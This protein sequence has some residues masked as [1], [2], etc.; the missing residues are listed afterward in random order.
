MAAAAAQDLPSGLPALSFYADRARATA[1]GR[2]VPVV[3]GWPAYPGMV[4]AI[5]VAAG[6]ESEDK[7]ADLEQGGFAGTLTAYEDLRFPADG[8]GLAFTD[9]QIEPLH[10]AAPVG[11][12]DYYAEPLYATV[13]VEL[14]HENRDERDRLHNELRRVLFPLRRWLPGRDALIRKVAVDGEKTEQNGGPPTAE[15][16]MWVYIS[17]FTV[18]VFYEMLEAANVRDASRVPTSIDVALDVQVQAQ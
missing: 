12:A 4:P 9:G 10:G 17:L 15:E 18:H 8:T 14:I 11:F 2:K 6:P 1:E 16:P 7:Q 5:G 3:R 13:V